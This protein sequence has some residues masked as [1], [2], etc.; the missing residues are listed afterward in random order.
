MEKD[1]L[2]K[3]SNIDFKYR[4]L[5]NIDDQMKFGTEIEFVSSNKNNIH[6]II[7]NLNH[8]YELKT[9]SFALSENNKIYNMFTNDKVFEIKT[10]VFNNSVK[11]F[12]CLKEICDELE[13]IDVK[14]SNQKGMHV[15]V[16]LSSFDE[17]TEYLYTFLKL[18]SI[19]EHVIFRF[20]YGEEEYSNINISSYSREIS[21]ILY[22]YLRRKNLSKDFKQNILELQ[23][24]LKC[25]SY[26][27]NFHKKDDKVKEE[28]VE[29]RTFNSTTNPIIIQNNINLLLSMISR[30]TYS[31]IDLDLIDY[32]FKNYDRGFY[33]REKY[34]EINLDDAIELSELLFETETD[35]DYFLKQYLIKNDIKTKKLVI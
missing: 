30:I 13:K 26:A 29:M 9:N 25:K 31:E 18:F 19:Y 10:P 11:S 4:N 35:K 14:N 21:N 16:N 34:S 2:E 6:K 12:H 32:R 15:H 20:S 7:K 17:E 8:K 3:L 23:E 1:I 24:L 33:K 28:T 5:L 22:N 27:L